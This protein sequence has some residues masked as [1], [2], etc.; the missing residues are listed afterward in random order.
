MDGDLW[1]RGCW[2]FSGGFTTGLR[3][4]FLRSNHRRNSR[5]GRSRRRGRSCRGW[6]GRSCR[7]WSRRS[8]RGW[9]GRSCRRGS[10]SCRGSRGRGGRGGRRFDFDR[11]FGLQGGD[12]ALGGLGETTIGKIG[13]HPAVGSFGLVE[14]ARELGDVTEGNEGVRSDVTGFRVVNQLLENPGRIGGLALDH[15]LR[16]EAGLRRGKGRVGRIRRR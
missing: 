5:G 16:T 10:R 15:E 2:N 13:F 11:R 4:G 7:S 12:A 14:V 9:G 8:C 1:F 3:A 6:G